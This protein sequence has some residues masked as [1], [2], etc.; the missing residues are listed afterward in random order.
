MVPGIADAGCPNGGVDDRA[1]SA[2]SQV[3]NV[4]VNALLVPMLSLSIL[5]FQILTQ[6]M[7]HRRQKALGTAPR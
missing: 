5:Y 4:T 3:T 1:P 7:N 6:R 2:L